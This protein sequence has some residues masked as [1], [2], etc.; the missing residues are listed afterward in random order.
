MQS[1]LGPKESKVCS[2]TTL[3]PEVQN[4]EVKRPY[5]SKSALPTIG[6]PQHTAEPS[7][8]ITPL[9][10]QLNNATQQAGSLLR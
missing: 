10:I 8:R 5:L 7:E 9:S 3:E 6:P 4:L 1:P 2:L